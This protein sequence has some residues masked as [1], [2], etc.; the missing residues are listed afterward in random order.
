MSIVKRV[1]TSIAASVDQLVSEI[2]NHEAAIGAAINEHSHKLSAARV[3]LNRLRATE[4]RTQEKR[5]EL[6]E[7]ETRWVERARAEADQDEEKALLCL[8]RRQQIRRKIDKLTASLAEYRQA[9]AKMDSNIQRF[10]EEIKTLKQRHELLRAR[11]TSAEVMSHMDGFSDALVNDLEQSFERWEIRV[12]Q[13]EMGDDGC[14]A[15]DE[16]EQHYVEQENREALRT[17]L[18]DLMAQK[19]KESDHGNA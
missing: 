11:Q 10:E 17:E 4:Q 12:A 15:F 19:G 7:T 3:K 1:Y 6:I 13:H 8:Q 16:L 5:A 18:T 14:N 2:E 9:I